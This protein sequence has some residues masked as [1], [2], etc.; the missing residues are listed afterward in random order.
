[1]Q[2]HPKTILFVHNSNDLYGSDIVLFNLIQALDKTEF[3]PIVVLPEDAR[4]IGRLSAKLETI[5]IPYKFVPLGVLRRRSL[6][7]RWIGPMCTELIYAIGALCILIHRERVDIVHTNTVTV[8]A[9]AFAAVLMNRPHIWHIH[10]IIP[11]KAGSRKMLHWVV[12]HLSSRIVAV[13]NAVRSHILLDQPRKVE[14]IEV[15][16]NGI[17]LSPFMSQECGRGSVRDELN[18]S[19]Q[20]LVVGMIGR[21]SQ[22]KGQSVFAEAAAR[23]VAEYR[24]LY[25][26]A[27]GGV[28][29]NQQEYMTVFQRQVESL[30]LK[31]FRICDYRQDIPEVLRSFDIFVLPSILPDPFPTVVIE[32]MASALPVIAS[33]CGGVS[34][35][36]VPGLTGILVPPGDVGALASAIQRLVLD[37]AGRVAMGEAARRRAKTEFQLARFVRQFERTYRSVLPHA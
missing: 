4:R 13:S 26:V 2:E 22:W 14:K 6:T 5:D 36:V 21:V 18:M 15:I 28:F 31:N 34:E 9:A 3:R 8:P 27:V 25:F 11:E 1:M 23:I 17:D 30:N 19:N 12:A 32:A 20:A 33:E 24:E 16:H 29:D 35:M 10:E 7:I 37:D